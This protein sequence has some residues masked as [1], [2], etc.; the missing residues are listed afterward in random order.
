MGDHG[1]VTTPPL[2]PVRLI[3]TD[4]D[5]TLLNAQRTVSPR[6]RAALAAAERAGL[7]VVFVTG[8]PPRFMEVVGGCLGT[9]TVAI[10]SNGALVFDLADGRVLSATPLEQEAASEVVKALRTAVPGV[11]FGIEFTHGFLHDP[12]YDLWAEDNGTVPG[13]L[14]AGPAEELVR[15]TS[16]GRI[17]KIVAQQRPM[18]DGSG[19]EPMEPDAFLRLG[20]EVIG[21]WADVTRSSPLLEISAVGVSK[22]ATLAGY[23]AE[24]GIAPEEVAAFGDMPNDLEMLAWAGRS[25]AMGN[26]HPAV[27]AATTRRCPPNTEDG[28]AQVVEELLASQ[29]RERRGA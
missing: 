25:Y 14:G 10:C 17:V 6:S 2:P 28:V 18:D 7:R 12:E 13:V 29:G 27:L 16:P 3:A 23:A 1:A 8:R 19:R 20:R 9:H 26:A 22:A 15:E 21:D 5:G 24:A 11:R 4:L